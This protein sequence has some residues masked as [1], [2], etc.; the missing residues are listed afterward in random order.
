MIRNVGFI[1]NLGT[2]GC[3]TCVMIRITV[4]PPGWRRPP[5]TARSWSWV[6]P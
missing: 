5:R 6:P 4:Q 1:E 3:G 2:W